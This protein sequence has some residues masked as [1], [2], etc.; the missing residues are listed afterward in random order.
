MTVDDT[1]KLVNFTKK[2]VII[3]SQGA[4]SV[5]NTKCIIILKQLPLYKNTWEYHGISQQIDVF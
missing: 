2:V 5:M 3:I 4:E 1:N